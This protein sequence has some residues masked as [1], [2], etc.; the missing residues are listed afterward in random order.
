M[1]LCNEEA[2]ALGEGEKECASVFSAV[3]NIE[4]SLAKTNI[5]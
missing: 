3:V 1:L 2:S 4:L 5:P